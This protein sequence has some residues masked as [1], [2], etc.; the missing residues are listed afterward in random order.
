MLKAELEK[1]GFGNYKI[2]ETRFV[3]DSIFYLPKQPIDLIAAHTFGLGVVRILRGKYKGENMLYNYVKMDAPDLVEEDAHD[4]QM[5]LR[6]YFQYTNPFAQFDKYVADM[7]ENR[8]NLASTLIINHKQYMRDYVQAMLHI[9][10][11]RRKATC[12]LI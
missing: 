3:P 2:H 1:R 4:E 11:R 10:G 8:W 7:I 5:M 12:I 9:I 6:M